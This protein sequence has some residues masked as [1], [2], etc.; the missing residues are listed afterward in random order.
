MIIAILYFVYHS[1]RLLVICLQKILWSH[2][3]VI[4]QYL[5]HGGMLLPSTDTA[6]VSVSLSLSV[7]PCLR[8]LLSHYPVS[9]HKICTTSTDRWQNVLLN[10]LP[11]QRSGRASSLCQRYKAFKWTYF[12]L[13]QDGAAGIV[14]GRTRCSL[15]C[16]EGFIIISNA[17]REYKHTHSHLQ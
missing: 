4:N 9:K 15:R 5:C 3:K 17:G 16:G 1:L 10:R 12:C 8:A 11:V 13:S 7:S 6:E 2:A 14:G